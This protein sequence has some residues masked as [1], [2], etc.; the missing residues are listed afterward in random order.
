[1]KRI[2]VLLIVVSALCMASSAQA[3]PVQ[4]SYKEMPADNTGPT[5]IICSASASLGQKC[6]RCHENVYP[7]GATMNWVCL[8]VLMNSSC[9]CTLGTE[10]KSCSEQGECWYIG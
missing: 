2:I 4:I 6:R 7:S 3:A 9:K 5:P 1:M 10:T 8:N